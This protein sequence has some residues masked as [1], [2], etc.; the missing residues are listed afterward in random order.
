MK[1]EGR[2]AAVLAALVAVGSCSME[3]VRNFMAM[4]LL[5]VRCYY[6]GLSG[7]H[8][9]TTVYFFAPLDSTQ[10]TSLIEEA[11]CRYIVLHCAS[12]WFKF[13]SDLNVGF[14][15]AAAASASPQALLRVILGMSD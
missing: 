15:V 5:P 3:C 8:L 2:L 4:Y 7:L 6:G 1:R 10:R 9:E 11:A 12:S 13:V 14:A